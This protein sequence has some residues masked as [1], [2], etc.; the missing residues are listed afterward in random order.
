MSTT[1]VLVRGELVRHLLQEKI[2]T[3]NISYIKYVENKDTHILVKQAASYE[4]LYAGNSLY[5][6]QEKYEQNQHNIKS[7]SKPKL[8]L[9]IREEFDALWKTQ[10]SAFSKAALFRL[11]KD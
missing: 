11:F 8:R 4:L 5:S 2:A 3:R 1:N 9:L 6:L 10:V 7:V